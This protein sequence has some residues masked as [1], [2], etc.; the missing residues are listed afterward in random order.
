MMES[1]TI[2]RRAVLKRPLVWVKEL[3][4]YKSIDPLA[5]IRQ[6]PF[7]MG[8]N[9]V[10][11]RMS[12]STEP[13]ESGHGIGKT[14][15]CRLIRYC[16]GENTFGQRHVLEEVKHCF[17][18]AY[19]GA[20]VEVEGSEWAVLRPL[21]TRRKQFALQGANLADLIES[22]ETQK[23][24][25]FA[26]ALEAAAL[27]GLQD[28][29]VLTN[30]HSIQWPHILAMC[31]RDQESRYDLWWNWRPSRS[32]SSTRKFDKPKV[33]AGLC[34]RSVL[35]LL[36]PEERRLRARLEK[37]ETDLPV[38]REKI[39]E[40]EA[41]PRFHINRLRTTLKS[42]FGVVDAADIP[43]EEGQL[44][45]V[46]QAADCRLRELQEELDGING[47]LPQLDR[48]VSMAAA[49][50]LE[51][52]EMF[53]QQAAASEATADGTE[54]TLNEL[55]ELRNQ[56]QWL[57]DMQESLCR[58]GRI[59][60]GMCSKVQEHLAD[61]DQQLAEQQREALPE[62]AQREQIA[63]ELSQRAERRQAPIEQMRERLNE[64]N[65]Q[66]NDLLERR[67]ALN[68]LI[69][70]LPTV[71]SELR[72]WN[73][74]LEGSVPN[75]ELEALRDDETKAENEIK[76]AK[77][78]L[79]EV[80]GKQ[81]ERAESFASRFNSMVQRTINDDFKGLVDINEDGVSFRINRGNSLF[82]EAYETLAVL[83]ADL[84]LL[85]ES[86]SAEVHHP[87]FLLHDSPRE[88][89]LNVRIYE[90]LLEVAN[91]LMQDV[92]EGEDMP[93]Q[94]IV[95]TTTPPSDTLK[96]DRVTMHY[97][98]SDDGSLFRMQLDANTYKE[99]EHRLFDTESGS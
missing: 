77:Q 87:G 53:G 7:S 34:V 75:K 46:S 17:P 52:S 29:K 10:Q 65:R 1:A 40:K 11:G 16:L 58:P 89:D 71:A 93:Y 68:G 85:A 28:R 15:V 47:R 86:S 30:G 31:S 22:D 43:L 78:K 24:E 48:R 82:G 69:K 35:G 50:L 25:D 61:I 14:T 26:A 57:V 79:S 59:T 51:Q 37:L 3:V 88:A 38:I 76:Q 95:T 41:E 90:R 56:K 19:V 84:A 32:E 80:V 6:M 60:F 44:F 91:S 73:G 92:R 64:L 62:V 97:L 9:I 54:N 74:I 81:A 5:E 72:K 23:Y 4:L 8:L 13:F 99:Q 42:E 98:S 63:A 12:D 67:L 83:L 36:D 45:G 49:S 94:Y 18:D 66:K 39:K 33:D 2:N 20:I 21:G 27:A 96:N 70:R 55:D